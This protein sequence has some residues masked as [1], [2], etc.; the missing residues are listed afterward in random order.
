MPVLHGRSS[1]R[2]VA[3]GLALFAALNVPGAL[4]FHQL[5]GS[6]C[7]LQ[8]FV[9]SLDAGV[10]LVV[11]AVLSHHGGEQALLQGVVLVARHRRIF[12][13]SEGAGDWALRGMERN[14][15]FR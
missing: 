6:A 15:V 14:C 4:K 5:N 2:L 8:R 3:F 10:A 7:V 1:K 12:A 9:M 11:R 13:P